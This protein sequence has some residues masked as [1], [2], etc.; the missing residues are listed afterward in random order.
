MQLLT[1]NS[2]FSY[3]LR[4]IL[5][6]GIRY[7]TE[8]LNA[9]PGVF[10]AL[11]P[12]VVDILVSRRLIAHICDHGYKISHLANNNLFNLLHVNAR[13]STILYSNLT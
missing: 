2:Q 8:K 11:V 6:R 3:V 12:T 13:Y 7:C 10:A 9:Q 5:R 4:R 1:F